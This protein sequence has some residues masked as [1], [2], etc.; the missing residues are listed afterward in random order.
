[1][2]KIRRFNEIF[3][4][5]DYDRIKKDLRSTHGWGEGSMTLCSDFEQSEY[6]E[7]PQSVIEYVDQFHI[8][9][10]D[11][12]SNKLRDSGLP[13]NHGILLGD[14]PFGTKVSHPRSFYNKLT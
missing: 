5:F 6:F 12:F 11:L 4:S 3:Q 8:Y 13:R 14:W 10:F 2:I 7:N 1:M 9:L